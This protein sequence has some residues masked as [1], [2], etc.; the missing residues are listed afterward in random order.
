M[1]SFAAIYNNM[2]TSNLTFIYKIKYRK[3][4][5]HL[6]SD[7]TPY[8]YCEQGSSSKRRNIDF[9]FDSG[10]CHE[11]KEDIMSA[12][13]QKIVK[14]NNRCFFVYVFFLFFFSTSGPVNLCGSHFKLPKLVYIQLLMLTLNM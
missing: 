8:L 12:N 6:G 14:K 11:K 2:Q 1:L 7:V 3:L 4:F 9:C 5:M 10:K 13:L